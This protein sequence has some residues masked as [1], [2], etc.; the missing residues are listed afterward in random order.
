M[1]FE[2]AAGRA[3][4]KLQDQEEMFRRNYRRR[5]STKSNPKAEA[6]I[7]RLVR[8]LVLFMRCA[9]EDGAMS[10]DRIEACVLRAFENAEFLYYGLTSEELMTMIEMELRNERIR[11]RNK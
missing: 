10:R 4:R 8:R 7:D 6:I 1:L 3:L 11:K 2:S 9:E 5:E